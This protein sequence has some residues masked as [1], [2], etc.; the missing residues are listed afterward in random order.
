MTPGRARGRVGE[1][2]DL[3]IHR[4]AFMRTPGRVSVT[5]ETRR[6]PTAGRSLTHV[7]SRADAPAELPPAGVD[8]I[9][10]AT[11]VSVI[12]PA[13]DAPETLL[14]CCDALIASEEPPD[15]IVV[16]DNPASANA[17]TARNLGAERATGDI[18]FFIDAD[19]E[20]RPDTVTRIRDAFD[21]DPSLAAV[22]GSYDDAPAAPGVASRFRNLL[23]H[24]VHQSAPGPASTF[25]TG[26]GAVRR[27]AFAQRRRLRRDGRVHGGRRLRNADARRRAADRARPEHPGHPPQALDDLEHDP[28][29]RRRSRRA[30]DPHPAPPPQHD[31]R[32]QPR[33]APPAQRPRVGDRAGRG[34]RSCCRSSCSRR[35][36]C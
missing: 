29:R 20:V 22:F 10:S 27:D 32:A 25:W 6:Q 13:T 33:L 9:A 34:S 2:R 23:H 7:Q 30:L 24:Q 16:I 35:W 12:V 4:P 11:T 31:E 26:L 15:E 18:L 5:G 19:V 28:H 1:G 21:A 17:A 14:R 3:S 36:R 8:H